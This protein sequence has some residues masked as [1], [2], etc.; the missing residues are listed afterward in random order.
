[1][2]ISAPKLH[3]LHIFEMPEEDFGSSCDFCQVMIVGD[4]PKEF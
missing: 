2:N 4:S 3:S 1:V